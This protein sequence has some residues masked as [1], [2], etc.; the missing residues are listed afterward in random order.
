MPATHV[1]IVD[2]HEVRHPYAHGGT[3]CLQQVIYLHPDG[4]TEEGYR[5]IWR[6]EADRIKPLRGQTR[7]PSL[8][9]AENLIAQAR[10]LGWGDFD[11]GDE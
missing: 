11:A 9:I 1:R 5:F 4:S 3:L 6:D 2:G 10:R 8:K 7:L